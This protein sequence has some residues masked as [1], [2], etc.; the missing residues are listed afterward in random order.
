MKT[1]LKIF[2]H[3]IDLQWCGILNTILT[4]TKVRD[5]LYYADKEKNKVH[6]PHKNL[7]FSFIK[8]NRINSIKIKNGKISEILHGRY[9]HEIHEKTHINCIHPSLGRCSNLKYNCQIMIL[10]KKQEKKYA[11][12]FSLKGHLMNLQILGQIW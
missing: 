4:L 1:S 12:L 2:F 6:W 11:N 7:K 5:N 3:F 8:T 10:Q 9:L